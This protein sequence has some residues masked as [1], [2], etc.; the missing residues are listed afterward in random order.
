MSSNDF[1]ARSTSLYSSSPVM[2]LFFLVVPVIIDWNVSYM[3]SCNGHMQQM[4]KKLI[5]CLCPSQCLFSLSPNHGTRK[6]L[7]V[8]D[9]SLKT[10]D[11]S[12]FKHFFNFY[13]AMRVW[14]N[15]FFL[16][17]ITFLVRAEA[18]FDLSSSSCWEGGGSLD[19]S[20]LWWLRIDFL[21]EF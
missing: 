1:R 19:E 16:R 8:I 13:D 2:L 15:F 9:I 4:R 10:F 6:E 5:M 20:E 18:P 3:P 14:R 21:L 11:L 7:K 17:V 12:L